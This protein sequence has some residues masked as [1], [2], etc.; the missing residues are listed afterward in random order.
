[1]KKML[2]LIT[3]L[4]LSFSLAIAV[5]ASPQGKPVLPNQRPPWKTCSLPITVNLIPKL[6]MKPL[7]RKPMKKDI[8]WRA[9]FSGH[10]PRLLISKLVS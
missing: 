2:V 1:M 3:V 5:T 9:V 10:L 8:L 7:Q 6:N 4:L